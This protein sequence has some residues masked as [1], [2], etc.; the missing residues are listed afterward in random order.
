[1]YIRAHCNTDDGGVHAHGGVGK[2]IRVQKHVCECLSDDRCISGELCLNVCIYIHTYIRM[3]MY[4]CMYVC[5]YVC[6]YANV[7]LMIDASQVSCAYMPVH[8]CMHMYVGMYVCKCL[9]YNRCISG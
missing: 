8:V 6:M 1:M 9:S 7:Y 5:M 4:L 2:P 3:Y